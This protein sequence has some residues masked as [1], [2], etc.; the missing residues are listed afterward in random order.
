MLNFFALSQPIKYS[1]YFYSMLAAH[2]TLQL[3]FHLD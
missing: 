3:P 2:M 1:L